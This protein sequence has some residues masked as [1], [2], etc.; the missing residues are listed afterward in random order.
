[1]IINKILTLI[2][3]I[4][5][6]AG[7]IIALALPKTGFFKETTKISKVSNPSRDKLIKVKT[8]PVILAKLG[9]KISTI[10]T[11]FPNEEVEIRSEISGKLETI[12]FKEASFVKKGALLFKINDNEL[13]AQFM[14]AKH[15]QTLAEQREK[16]LR[17]LFNKS[18]TSQADYD[19]SVANLNIAKAETQLI[20]IHLDKTNILAPF[21]GLIGFRYVSEGSFITQ[22]TP[23][24]VLQ[25]NNIVK[26]DFAVPEKYA[27]SIK[28]GDEISF[29]IQ[30][31]SKIFSAKI[32]AV[33]PKIEPAT[34]T[35]S[36]RAS[37][38]N[39]DNI[40]FPGSLVTVNISIK[41][42][43]A[44]M[45][46][47]FTLIPDLKGHKVFIYKDG[48]AEERRVETGFRSDETVEITNGLKQGDM[49][50]TTGILQLRTG[51]PVEIEQRENVKSQAV[52]DAD[53]GI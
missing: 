53:K 4:I 9:S 3:A 2:I 43:D 20:K 12:F 11:I 31:T 44:I 6:L 26:I 48:K 17:M 46:P 23:I 1:M 14:R 15:S 50:I 18:L 52:S 34:R 35:L 45:I 16:R 41:E 5:I 10:G 51:M 29:N 47:S 33:Q 36:L 24:A 49:L 42:K 25:D 38:S 28:M 32:Y 37:T 39:P 40:F 27:G 8:Q 13:Q 22:S 30:G 7:V 21:A 19:T